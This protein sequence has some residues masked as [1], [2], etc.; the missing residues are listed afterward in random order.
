MGRR[1]ER[2]LEQNTT[3]LVIGGGEVADAVKVAERYKL[4]FPVLADR[5]RSVYRDYG[6][7]KQL[8]VIQQSGT[9]LVDQDGVIRY[10]KQATNPYE[11]LDREELMAAVAALQE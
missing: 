6:F 5:D 4:P 7:N 10:L 11:A 3:V 1:H 9:V 2:L 8:W